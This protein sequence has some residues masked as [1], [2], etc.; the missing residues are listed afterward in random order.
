VPVN[1]DSRL[2]DCAALLLALLLLL[3]AA[4]SQSDRSKAV[5]AGSCPT[6]SKPDTGHKQATCLIRVKCMCDAMLT[7][8]YRGWLLV[9][10]SAQLTAMGRQPA[11]DN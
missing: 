7:H 2:A 11:I 3:A 5:R 1:S 8:P 9:C 6:A 10:W 4:Y